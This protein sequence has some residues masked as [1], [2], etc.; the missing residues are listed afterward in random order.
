MAE[1]KEKSTQ[2]SGA[3]FLNNAMITLCAEAQGRI[4]LTQAWF[5]YLLIST[6]DLNENC[7]MK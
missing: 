5:R 7:L 2:K 1:E 4:P 3:L 6:S